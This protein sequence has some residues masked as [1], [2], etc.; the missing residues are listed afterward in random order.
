VAL[1]VAKTENSPGEIERQP[2]VLWC[3]NFGQI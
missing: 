1:G 2:K 3:S